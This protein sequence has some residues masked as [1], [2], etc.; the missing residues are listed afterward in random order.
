MPVPVL[1]VSLPCLPF[2]FVCLRVPSSISFGFPLTTTAKRAPFASK[3]TANWLKQIA[4]F[5]RQEV[6]YK[7]AKV[8]VPGTECSERTPQWL[9]GSARFWK[10]SAQDTRLIWVLK[11][12][13]NKYVLR[14]P[15]FGALQGTLKE[16]RHCRG[17][18]FRAR[19][20]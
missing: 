1:L 6:K 5:E 9:I 3:G 10:G 7:P 20:T 13:K 2:G 18:G 17:G 12:K 15:F 14:V 4:R 11:K 19:N 8:A 16:N